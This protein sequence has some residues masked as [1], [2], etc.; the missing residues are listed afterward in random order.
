M[1]DQEAL[2]YPSWVHE[3]VIIPDNENPNRKLNILRVEP[4]NPLGREIQG[5]L[6][7]PGHPED[8]RDYACD[9]NTFMAVWCTPE[10]REW[11]KGKTTTNE[12]GSQ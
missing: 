8:G 12:G 6:T 9:R 4:T 5:V 1:A 7:H 10:Q 11:F 2:V 3:H